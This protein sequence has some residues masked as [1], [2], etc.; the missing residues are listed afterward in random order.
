MHIISLNYPHYVSMSP[1]HF[2]SLFYSQLV[3]AKT[4]NFQSFTT[5]FNSSHSS[6][7]NS[8]LHHPSS[9][10]LPSNYSHSVK[11][12]YSIFS[13][14]FYY[15]CLSF[16]SNKTSLNFQIFSSSLHSIHYFILKHIQPSNS[17]LFF[18]YQH[19]QLTSLFD[20][21]PFPS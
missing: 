19:L 6:L 21:Y 1:Q 11:S 2:L 13:I 20:D 9:T 15:H 4:I 12:L 3:L 18:Y 5:I 10:S 8:F 16:N 17:P 7:L 14:L